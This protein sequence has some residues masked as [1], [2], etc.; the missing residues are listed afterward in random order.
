MPDLA[1][2]PVPHSCGTSRPELVTH[3]PD[4][5]AALIEQRRFRVDQL[6]ELEAS[7]P[8]PEALSEVNEAL[9]LAANAALREINAA[10][11]RMANGKYGECMSCGASISL[12]R[13]EILPAAAHCMNCLQPASDLPSI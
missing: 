7:S 8:A 5:H 2:K 9:R 12:E 11:G 3:L 4:L 1:G 13:L 6:A 10:L